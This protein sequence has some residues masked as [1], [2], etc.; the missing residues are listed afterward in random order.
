[1][2]P[3]TNFLVES[4]SPNFKAT[5]YTAP[6]VSN[7]VVEYPIAKIIPIKANPA[8]AP[9]DPFMFVMDWNNPNPNINKAPAKIRKPVTPI[10]K[11]NRVNPYLALSFIP[12]ASIA[13][14]VS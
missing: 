14:K 2:D 8:T 1:M 3:P 9:K 13:V 7:W 6:E 11:S 5:S 10:P 4:S 12:S